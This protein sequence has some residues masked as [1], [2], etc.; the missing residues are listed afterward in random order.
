MPIA[1]VSLKRK[2]NKRLDKPFGIESFIERY[3]KAPQQNK[4]LKFSEIISRTAIRIAGTLQSLYFTN[5]SHTNGTVRTG[6]TKNTYF[7]IHTKGLSL[8]P[9][10]PPYDTITHYC[11]TG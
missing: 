7:C 1:T 6:L 2:Q 3:D 5:K 4:E 10:P 8:A 9:L 11:T